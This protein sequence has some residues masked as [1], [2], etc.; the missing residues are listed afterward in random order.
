MNPPQT[1]PTTK[2]A[3]FLAVID[4]ISSQNNTYYS[5]SEFVNFAQKL[6]LF[7]LLF[8]LRWIH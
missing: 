4:Q 7:D 8:Q 2:K 5:L 1:K 3:P 6:S